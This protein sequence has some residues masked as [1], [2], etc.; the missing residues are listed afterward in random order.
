MATWKVNGFR[1]AKKKPVVNM[2]LF[3][4]FD[5]EV[6][7]LNKPGV[8]V[9]FWHVLR[10]QNKLADHIVNCRLSGI[11]VKEATKRLVKEDG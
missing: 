9:F 6:T 1:T 4:K 7:P 10:E 2:D 5:E 8:Q 11:M 3:K